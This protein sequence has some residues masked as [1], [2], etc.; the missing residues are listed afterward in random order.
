VRRNLHAGRLRSGGLSLSVLTA[1]ELE[2]I[3][4]A[5]LEVLE[6]TGVFVEDPEAMAAFEAGGCAVD[7]EARIVRIPGYVVEEAIRSAPATITLA[8]RIPA[9]D[10]VL[11]SSRVGFTNFGEGIQVVDP[12]DG[13]LR[14]PTKDDVGAAAR[15][16]D[17]LDDIDVLERP[18]G[19]HDVPPEV[20]PLHN[21]E[22]ILSNTT[23]HMFIGPINGTMLRKIVAMAAAIVGGEARLRARPLVSFITCPVSPLK[24][25]KD[26]C[27][28]IMESAR[29][30]MACN[31]LSMA[32][33]GGSS[34]VTLAGTLVTHNAEVLSGVTLSQLTKRGA[35]VIYG[36]ST[37]AMDL[38]LAAASVGSPEL[39]LISAAV[40][41][42]SRRYLLP[43][44]VAGA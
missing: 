16:I 29:A 19:A 24:L 32:M 2:D 23:K 40:V 7:R 4:L 27:E 5:T 30:G 13:E 8:G 36:S 3:H 12:R 31:I 38:R 44:W 33:A 28:I 25:V 11:E 1:D 42:M 41:Q 15:L 43:S 35:P 34:P 18:I 21:A 10:F 20:S 22:A 17:A 39:A 14:E 6:R 37:T 26:C 9:R